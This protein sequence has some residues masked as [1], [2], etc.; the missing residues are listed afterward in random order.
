MLRKEGKKVVKTAGSGKKINER[1]TMTGRNM[2]KE[3][4]GLRKAGLGKYRGKEGG[5]GMGRERNKGR[6]R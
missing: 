4:R 6:G 2:V 3:E 5:L 1:V